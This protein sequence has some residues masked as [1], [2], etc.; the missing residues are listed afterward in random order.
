MGKSKE[1]EKLLE[2]YR[3]RIASEF[4]VKKPVKDFESISKEKLYSH[5][6]LQFKKEYMPKQVSF[7]EK[8]CNW[9]EGILKLSPS[10]KDTEKLKNDIRERG[11]SGILISTMSGIA[12]HGRYEYEHIKD[13]TYIFYVPNSGIDL[14]N[15]GISG[16][17]FAI[18]R[19]I[20]LVLK[21]LFS[22]SLP[23]RFGMVEK[24]VN[25]LRKQRRKLLRRS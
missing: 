17:K 8:A 5:E 10:K 16:I 9:S 13:G 19:I 18:N 2:E 14:G 25:L 6:Y 4:D 7:Y 20:T 15:E 12:C 24:N 22:L 23:I 3:Q 21:K 1:V 11:I